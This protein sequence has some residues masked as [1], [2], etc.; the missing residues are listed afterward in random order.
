MKTTDNIVEFDST[1]RKFLKISGA[2]AGV[3]LLGSL[4]SLASQAASSAPSTVTGYGVTTAALKDWSLMTDSIGVDM[5]YTGT[6]NNVGVFLHSVM[7]NRLG[8]EIDIFVFEG[9]VEDILGPAGALLQL[10]TDNPNFSLWKRSPEI[11]TASDGCVGP[12]GVLWGSPMIGNADSFGYFPDKLGLSREEGAEELSWDLVFE[13]PKTRGRVAF[14]KTW[15]YNL[16]SA[17]NYLKHHGREK[18]VD[19]ADMTPGEAKSVVD[20]LISRKKAGQFRTL[21][22]S[23]EEQIQLLVTNEVDVINCWQPAVKEANARLGAGK[24]LYAYTKEGYYK[25]SHQAYVASQATQ[26]GRLDEIYKTLNYFLDGEYRAYQAIQRGYGGPN[27][28]LGI[29]YAKEHGWS[30]DDIGELEAVAEKIKRKFAK[31]YWSTTTPSYGEQLQEE[32]QRFLNA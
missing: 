3:A 12:D 6:N 22:G 29:K 8:R 17:A 18:I 2:G 9:G 23:F 21:Y 15:N 14:G 30:S 20:F 16:P 7:A 27:M 4:S 19:P 25:W 1:R 31:P 24:V 28:D 13:S 10:D 26:R 32:W 5:D 11:W